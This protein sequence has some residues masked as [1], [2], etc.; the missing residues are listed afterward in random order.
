MAKSN[1]L[2]TVQIEPMLQE[3][4][5]RL[6]G[7]KL[8]KYDSNAFVRS[9][10]LAIQTNENIVKAMQTKNGQAS[11]YNAMCYA[12]A[13]GLSLNPQEGKAALIAYG[14]KVDYQIMSNGLKEIALSAG[15]IIQVVSDVVKSKDD[16]KILKTSDGDKYQW[17]PALADRGEAIGYFCAI[18]LKSGINHVEYMTKHEVEEHRDKYA[19]RSAYDSSGKPRYGSAWWTSFDGMALKTVVKQILRRVSVGVESENFV[20][21]SVI[22]NDNRQEKGL[23]SKTVEETKEQKGVT[24]ADLTEIIKKNDERLN[25]KT[26]EKVGD[27][28]ESAI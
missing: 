22:K 8:R 7:Y 3:W 27:G 6:E 16:F 24:S 12:A 1:N 17:S 5:P 2:P 28:E 14:D 4:T 23:E 11:L 15:K 9:A 19:K 10:F 25:G 20:L 13:T 21:D 18:R 26:A